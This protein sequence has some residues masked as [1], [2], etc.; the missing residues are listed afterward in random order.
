MGPASFP[1]RG[2]GSAGGCHG[3]PFAS[4]VEG[5]TIDLALAEACNHRLRLRRPLEVPDQG[6]FLGQHCDREQRT[7]G[8]EVDAAGRSRAPQR[9][10]R[11]R[12]GQI[13][14][15]DTAAEVIRSEPSTVGRQGKVKDEVVVRADRLR[16]RRSEILDRDDQYLVALSPGEPTI[17][18][19]H[20]IGAFPAGGDRSPAETSER[21]GEVP[22]LATLAPH[23][24]DERGFTGRSRTDHKLAIR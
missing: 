21:Q 5:G 4:G 13:P 7:V 8:V 14:H 20:A 12:P 2:E 22:S 11:A 1:G 19:V 16:R 6:A 15:V 10:R 17:R 3:E 18:R 24:L 23:Q 9:A